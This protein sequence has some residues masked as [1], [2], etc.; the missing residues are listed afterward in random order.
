MVDVIS[1]DHCDYT[2]A[3]KTE[4]GDFSKTPGGLPGLETLFPLIYTHSLDKARSPL[5]ALVRLMST[6]P[7]RIFGLD[8]RKGDIRAGMDADLLIYDPKPRSYLR[9]DDLHN[10]AGYTP[11]EGHRLRGA[12]RTVLCLSLIHI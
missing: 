4:S 8:H 7:A 6:N 12:V 3:Q 10:I 2:L 9:S 5:N 1:T 11:Y